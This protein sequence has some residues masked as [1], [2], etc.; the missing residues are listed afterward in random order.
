MAN[1][2]S[3]VKR[4]ILAG[5]FLATAAAAGVLLA[6]APASGADE[7]ACTSTY[8]F[9]NLLIDESDQRDDY[10]C[11]D[12]VR[13]VDRFTWNGHAWAL[14]NASNDLL[15][16][17]LQDLGR[18][19]IDRGGYGLG[20]NCVVSEPPRGTITGPEPAGAELQGPGAQ[21]PEV[22]NAFDFLDTYSVCQSYGS[23]GC[24]FAFLNYAHD[25]KGGFAIDLGSPT[26][27]QPA[28][29]DYWKYPDIYFGATWGMGGNQYVAAK[30]FPDAASAGCPSDATGAAW[31]I[32][33]ISAG[34]T[35]S[36]TFMQC[37]PTGFA[38][39]YSKQ[40]SD[41]L[42]FFDG[43]NV[44]VWG[45]DTATGMP[46]DE[47]AGSGIPGY[48]ESAVNIDGQ[49]YTGASGSVLM[50]VTNVRG[51]QD[52]ARL[53]E[54]YGPGTSATV[55]HR[56]TFPEAPGF[57]PPT[58]K[59]WFSGS[60]NRA[61]TGSYLFL[62]R[63]LQNNSLY[64]A[65]L[66]FDI[67]DP[68]NP[69][70]LDGGYDG[71]WN[72][73]NSDF[74]QAGA[75]PDDAFDWSTI[76][77]FD[78]SEFLMLRKY[79]MARFQYGGPPVPTAD[80]EIQPPVAFPGDTITLKDRSTSADGVALWI[81]QADGTPVAGQYVPPSYDLNP[82]TADVVWNTAADMAFEPSCAPSAPGPYTAHVE[83]IPAGE[84]DRMDRVI[85]FQ[86]KPGVTLTV[87]PATAMTGETVTLKGT[88]DGG[89]P[90][91]WK[92]KV[93]DPANTVT[94]ST[95]QGNGTGTASFPVSITQAGQWTFEL[96]A[97]YQHT[98]GG[99]P[100]E[101]VATPVVRTYSSVAPVLD[102][103]PGAPGPN[104]DVVLKGDQSLLGAGL[105]VTY[106]YTLNGNV[107]CSG[108]FDSDTDTVPDCPV[109]QLA[110]G[111]YT[112]ELT[113][114]PGDGT[115]P[116]SAEATFTVTDLAININPSN[117]ERGELVTF[118]TNGG[119]WAGVWD[120]GGTGCTGFSQIYE[121]DPENN[122]YCTALP[123][124]YKYATEGT[125]TVTFT[126]LDGTPVTA[127]LTV[128]P[129]GSCSGGVTCTYS[130]SPALFTVP[131]DGG[132]YSLRITASSAACS[133][134]AQ[135]LSSWIRVT[136]SSGSGTR[137]L[138][139]VVS[140]NT[141]AYREGTIRVIAGQTY[142]ITVKQAAGATCDPIDAQFTWSPDRDTFGVGERVHFTDTSSGVASRRWEVF[143]EGYLLPGSSGEKDF[144][145]TPASP[146]NYSVKLTVYNECQASDVKEVA[147]TVTEEIP[148]SLLFV[149][150][151]AHAPGLEG[152]L[153]R[154]DVNLFN[155]SPTEAL[156]VELQLLPFG[157]DNSDPQ[158]T[159]PYLVSPLRTKSIQDVVKTLWPGV[160][161]LSAS[162]GVNLSGSSV[163]VVTARTYNLT[164]QGTY[165]S[166]IPM[167]SQP[168]VA[169]DAPV[170]G[171]LR[172]DG[173]FRTN[174]L[175]TNLTGEPIGDVVIQI[176]DA[177]GVLKG[178]TGARLLPPYST[179]QF[180]KVGNGLNL[181]LFSI[182]VT[183]PASQVTVSASVVENLTGDSV[184]VIPNA[185]DETD[186]YLPGLAHV[187]GKHGT[188]WRSDLA[189][190][191][192]AGAS[193]NLRFN[194][195]LWRQN[196]KTGAIETAETGMI[197]LAP[198]Q[199]LR[200]EDV[201]G[202]GGNIFPG[203]A[204][205]DTVL[206]YCRVEV[207]AGSAAPLVQAQ[208]YTSGDGGG[209]YG[210]GVA[211]YG[212]AELLETGEVG[213]VAGISNAAE[214]GVGFRS[215]LGFLCTGSGN[216]VLGLT[217][218]DASGT[219][220]AQRNDVVIEP[221]KYIQS[222]VT[223]LLPDLAGQ[224]VF[225]T[226][227]VEVLGGGPVAAYATIVDNETNDGIFVP[228]LKH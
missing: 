155:P 137:T 111:S 101:A 39:R 136:P 118:T 185:T 116:V 11:F 166:F 180:V 63:S 188:F 211:A 20:Q 150:G 164:D 95:S 218:Y 4:P 14:V 154:T 173:D 84:G 119:S 163:P 108:T 220:L 55:T 207:A 175:V 199:S 37:A 201:L 60:I 124:Q 177:S 47:A 32:Y 152:T 171:G 85:P 110:V 29:A 109:G 191:N 17:D 21:A 178:T 83:I 22:V 149:S 68:T 87:S 74:N 212:A 189:F 193:A 113:L 86:C 7:A 156:Q 9:S 214:D 174:V 208:T 176:Y 19:M 144:Y 203:A 134:S 98:V 206:G 148:S 222:A 23:G 26:A 142:T 216:C 196:V 52:T 169:G 105:T 120:F 140:A 66:L 102:V 112:A 90:V 81:T 190:T 93:T 43:S 27:S 75:D 106:T 215:N 100:W 221:G 89:I 38:P 97:V 125:K 143:Q 122:P 94:E 135:S 16:Y 195:H 168:V 78:G 104:D 88:V 170:L 165:G 2:H 130:I 59:G 31:G 226:L 133:W 64:A 151:A 153:W 91:Q 146:G 42:F 35:P 117:P 44:R 53:Y 225:G 200:F 183:A 123:P 33:R 227:A 61:P 127:T 157:A 34:A 141:G 205:E 197:T 82:P 73:V 192:P 145:W 160:D 49:G 65:H 62:E 103:V 115:P 18:G 167:F 172:A 6:P 28:L 107:E 186:L 1:V 41:L 228:V 70:I 5:V 139:V 67:T 71:Y 223:T 50:L 79:M 184:L 147:F 126:P 114:D 179:V 210:Q 24:R 182:R 54:V 96:T 92:W 224:D 181:P 131:S 12:R 77:S 8:C 209:A 58:I 30:G 217:V 202:P 25:A 198:G 51:S 194:L 158:Y 121:C 3:T 219:V 129:T 128:Q 161:Q 159:K 56:Y 13:F 72:D 69:V 48:G 132:S 138:S 76:F 57:D 36:F 40:A 99:T 187:P 213:H 204:E 162:V 46:Y 80:L 10:T 15:L 45:L